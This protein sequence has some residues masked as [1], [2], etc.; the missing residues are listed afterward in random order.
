MNRTFID[1]YEKAADR[2]TLSLRGLQ[3]ED[4]LA[5]PV[6][7][8]W[9]IQ[10]IA[11]HLA[12]S[13]L[14]FADRIKRVIAEENASLLAWSENRWLKHLSYDAQSAEDAGKL[15]ELTRRQTSRILRAQ[16]DEAFDR[17][18]VHS[19][20]GPL[21]LKDLILKANAHLDH[22]LKFLVDKREKLGKIMW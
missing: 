19:E 17:K 16:P 4:L 10:Q 15:V 9:S 2:L 6:P 12:D 5:F 13:E 14:V 8:T 7:G 3:R 11:I 1:D 22:H 20:V 21:S 18:G